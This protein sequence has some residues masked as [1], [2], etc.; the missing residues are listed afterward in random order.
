MINNFG[1][2]I[3]FNLYEKNIEY[4]V[5]ING[6]ITIQDFDK[7]LGIHLSYGHNIFIQTFNARAMY[8][9]FLIDNRFR[10][11]KMLGKINYRA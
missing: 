11:K 10:E 7:I 1:K 4:I 5:V 3:L 2:S 9:Y 6:K 8:F